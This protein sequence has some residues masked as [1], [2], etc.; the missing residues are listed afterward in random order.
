MLFLSV[1]FSS[2]AIVSARSATAPKRQLRITCQE[3]PARAI[4][5]WLLND[6]TARWRR[7]S[8]LGAVYT[9]DFPYESP[10]DSVFLLKCVNKLLQ[11]VTEK[12][13]DPYSVS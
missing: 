13:L 10:Y 7:R 2:L 12:E 1:R 4:S 6:R 8:D 9:C 11:W 5:Q 3:G